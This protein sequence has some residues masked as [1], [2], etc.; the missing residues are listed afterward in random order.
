MNGIVSAHQRRQGLNY[1]INFGVE[2]PRLKELAREYEKSEEL[3]IA[4]WQENIRECKLLAIFLLPQEC[5][6]LLADK[7]I[8]ETPFTEIADH[9]AMNILCKL[10]NAI[11]KAFEWN[12]QPVELHKYCGYLTLTHLLRKGGT[13]TQEQETL[14]YRQ[15]SELFD[16]NCA[17]TTK[18]CAGKALC[19]YIDED[20]ARTARLLDSVTA[21]SNVAGF[22]KEYL[23]A[24]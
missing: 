12:K 14:F 2:I 16:T 6:P 24:F 8:A 11:D 7:W 20:N 17:S 22:V 15:I 5:Y 18:R 21:N 13:L 10:P 19:A 1:K 9:L 4:L 3:A 23:Q